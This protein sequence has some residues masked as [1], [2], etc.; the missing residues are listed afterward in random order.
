MVRIALNILN[1]WL[2][3]TSMYLLKYLFN[4]YLYNI[5]TLKQGEPN[6]YVL[7]TGGQG[8]SDFNAQQRKSFQTAKAPFTNYVIKC[9][10]LE[11]FAQ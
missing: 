10:I 2:K 11:G 9:L 3:E 1:S 6:F 4:V 7:Q 8:L 5:G